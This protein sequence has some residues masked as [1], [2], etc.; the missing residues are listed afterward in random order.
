MNIRLR[1]TTLAA[2][3]LLSTGVQAHPLGGR[4]DAHL[5]RQGQHINHHLDHQAAHQAALGHYRAA[6]RLDRRGDRI[7]RR[8][9]RRH[10]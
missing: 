10:G 9:D 1:W 8:R 4:I 5:D 6:L 7:E 2:A 3:L